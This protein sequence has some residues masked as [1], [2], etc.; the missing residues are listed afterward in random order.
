MT[1]HMPDHPAEIRYLDA[2]NT[3]QFLTVEQ[4]SRLGFGHPQSI[5]RRLRELSS[6]K[7]SVIGRYGDYKRP[8][9]GKYPKKLHS[10]YFMT[11]Y[12]ARTLEAFQGLDEDSIAYR[13]CT[14]PPVSQYFHHLNTIDF[15]IETIRFCAEKE[16]DLRFFHTYLD[17][18]GSNRNS[19]PTERLKSKTRVLL[20]WYGEETAFIPDVIFQAVVNDQYSSF[21]TAEIYNGYSTDRVLRQLKKHVLALEQG[22]I[23][24]AYSIEMGWRVLVVFDQEAAMRSVLRRV[25][26]VLRLENPNR[27]FVFNTLDR[28]RKDFHSGWVHGD[29][30]AGEV[31]IRR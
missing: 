18:S 14:K 27:F 3:Y 24:K 4:F 30:S 7:K 10:I 8:Q 1:E 11:E 17:R 2:L 29:G 23:S 26:D 28:I 16:I 20:D 21:Y 31:F 9:H 5:R 12:G 15:Q 6:G 13:K 19:P 25:K 22:V